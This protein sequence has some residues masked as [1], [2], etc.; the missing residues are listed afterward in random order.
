MRIE[1]QFDPVFDRGEQRGDDRARPERAA[2]AFDGWSMSP[3][4][5]LVRGRNSRSAATVRH[6]SALEQL[7]V[8]R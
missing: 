5:P 7:L 1:P 2:F 6:H 3:L 4:E 8:R